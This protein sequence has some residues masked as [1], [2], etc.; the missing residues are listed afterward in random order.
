M[1][2]N[3]HAIDTKRILKIWILIDVKDTPIICTYHGRHAP[4]PEMKREE[5]YGRPTHRNRSVGGMIGILVG[6]YIPK[7]EQNAHSKIRQSRIHAIRRLPVS[8]YKWSGQISGPAG[9]LISK[10][11]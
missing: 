3:L 10:I 11:D 9:L 7:E 2:E 5:D 1:C 8:R 6:T 4:M